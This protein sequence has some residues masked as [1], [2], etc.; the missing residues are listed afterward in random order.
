MNFAN[1]AAFRVSVLQLIEGDDIT[2]STFSPDTLDLM[3]AMGENRVYRDL[4]ASTMLAA[5][6]VAV[7]SNAASLPSDLIELKEVYFSGERPLEI[8]PL[9][10]LRRHE[11]D[12]VVAGSSISRY[13]AQ[14]GDTLRFWPTAT[15]TVLGKYYKRPSELTTALSTTFTRYP[16]CF[17]FAALVES[18]PFLGFDDRMPMW[19]GKYQQ[20]I[21]NANHDER[22]RVWG[23]SPLRIRTR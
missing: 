19:E 23:G 15:G 8:V 18:A 17:I 21:A 3:I 7:A 5:L 14:D 16:E 4:R 2:D 11:A 12:E 1:Y 9:D 22:M 13:A 6:S 20:S 10:H